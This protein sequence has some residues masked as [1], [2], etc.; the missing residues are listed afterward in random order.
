M[1]YEAIVVHVLYR[2]ARPVIAIRLVEGF[3]NCK[4]PAKNLAF[5]Y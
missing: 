4:R 1:M 5:I 3:A 2:C